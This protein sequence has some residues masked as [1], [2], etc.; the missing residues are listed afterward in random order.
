MVVPHANKRELW[1][2]NNVIL[3]PSLFY[4][5]GKEI[6][7]TAF[8]ASVIFV[9]LAEMGDKTQLLAMAFACKFRWQTVMWGVFAATA[10]NHLLAAAAGNYLAAIVPMAYIKIA[11][12]AS[13]IIFGL[14]TIRGDTLEGED[15]RYN[16]NPFWTVAIAFF[17]AEMGDKT[18]LATIALA[19][20][21]N[22]IIT[23]W[24]GTTTG[25]IISD[26]FGIIVGNVMGKHIPDRAIKW[27]S[28]LVFIAFGVFGLYDNLPSHVW[29]LSTISGSLIALAAAM[30]GVARLSPGRKTQLPVCENREA[31]A[32]NK[33]E[34]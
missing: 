15:K 32:S 24:L 12:A 6:F 3:K 23:V 11:A 1:C 14:W 22:T 17:M 4:F 2:D 20:K 16:F 18:Q 30:Y 28:A 7:M 21:Y 27:V 26:A 33:E 9:V 19:V 8:I 5:A 31:I 13:F 25:M 34:H 10:V 29:T